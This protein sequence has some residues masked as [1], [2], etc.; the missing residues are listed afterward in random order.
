MLSPSGQNTVLIDKLHFPNGV[1]LSPK[2]DFVLVCE[3]YR[4]RVLR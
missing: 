3:T 2:Q 4:R 1:Q